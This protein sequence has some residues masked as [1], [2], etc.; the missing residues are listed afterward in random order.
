MKLIS[1]LTL[2]VTLGAASMHAL[3]YPVR[4]I[5]TGSGLYLSPQISLGANMGQATDISWSGDG[6]LGPFTHREV[7][8]GNAMPT[9]SGCS[10]SNSL[11]FTFGAGAGFYRF[12]D[13]SLLT[14][15]ITDGKSCIDF[16]VGSAT[17]TITHEITGG[18][19][20]FKNATGSLTV[21]TPSSYPLLFDATGQQP[22]LIVFP[23]GQITGTITVPDPQ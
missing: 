10:G 15:K 9:G 23:G 8:A 3:Q 14:Y 20:R 22:V 6:S 19:G 5:F 12:S 4:M 17:G 11:A 18:T 2:G 13:G 21:T 7:S 16:T 1:T